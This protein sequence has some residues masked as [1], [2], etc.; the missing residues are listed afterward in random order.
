[1]PKLKYQPPSYR[2]H[3]ASGQAVVTIH[4]RDRY[5]G[6]F[7]STESHEKYHQLIAQWVTTCKETERDSAGKRAPREDLRISELLVA[8]LEFADGYYRRNGTPSGEVDNVKDAARPLATLYKDARVSEFGPTDLKS[9]RDAMIGARLSRKVVNARINR[10]R[11]VFKW[12]VENEFVE[13]HILQALQAIAPLKKGRSTARETEDVK[14]VPVSHIEKV[15]PLVTIQVRAM[16]EL[17]RLTGM[18]PGELVV[19]RPYDIDRGKSLWLYRPMSHKTE[20]H[21]I[22]REIFIGPRAQQVLQPFLLRDAQCF[23]FSPREAMLEHK[24]QRRLNAK[25]PKVRVAANDK[26]RVSERVGKRYTR[27]SYHNAVYKA[28]CKVGIRPWGPN[29]LRHNA[30]TMLREQFG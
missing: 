27:N 12:G 5:L 17:Q 22:R 6:K 10:I 4:G 16:I 30:A 1:M 21:G 2:R 8:Y 7:G 18:R 13:P 26:L 14:P 20:H 11:R 24:R 15:L 25:N 29:R 3:T 28:C 23:L 19:M 9:V